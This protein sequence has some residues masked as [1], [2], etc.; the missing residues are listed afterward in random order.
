MPFLEP[1]N[2]YW[3]GWKVWAVRHSSLWARSTWRTWILWLQSPRSRILSGKACVVSMYVKGW[4]F[5]G[6][7]SNFEHYRSEKTNKNHCP[8]QGDWSFQPLLPS[9]NEFLGRD[10]FFLCGWGS[11]WPDTGSEKIEQNEECGFGSPE[12]WSLIL[13]LLWLWYL[14]KAVPWSDFSFFTWWIVR[15]GRWSLR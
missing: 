13:A 3:I 15:D 1:I 6:Y 4:C 11:V 9:L 8:E 12:S 7:L 2:M 10:Y 5:L 14:R